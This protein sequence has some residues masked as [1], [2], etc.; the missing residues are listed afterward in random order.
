MPLIVSEAKKAFEE[1]RQKARGDHEQLHYEFDKVLLECVD[2]EI[3]AEFKRE[4]ENVG[5]WYS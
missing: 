2:P 4:S 1:A 3:K 5:F